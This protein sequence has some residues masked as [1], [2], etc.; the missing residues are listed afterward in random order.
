[1]TLWFFSSFSFQVD[2]VSLD[3]CIVTFYL[4]ISHHF[5]VGHISFH[6]SIL[7]LCRVRVLPIISQLV[8]QFLISG[9]VVVQLPIFLSVPF[10]T[11]HIKSLDSMSLDIVSLMV[12]AISLAS[13]ILGHVLSHN[14]IHHVLRVA[15]IRQRCFQE[16][17]FLCI[18]IFIKRSIKIEHIIG[19]RVFQHH[20]CNGFFIGEISSPHFFL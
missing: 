3:T 4:S 18:C 19:R 7:Y 9:Y 10:V 5:Q 14:L 17:P 12:C 11:A 2:Q 1:M 16:L 13:P 15:E 6:H 8:H 20:F